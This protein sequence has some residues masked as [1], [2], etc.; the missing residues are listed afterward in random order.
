VAVDGCCPHC[1]CE[2]LHRHSE[3]VSEA[4]DLVRAYLRVRRII[5]EVRRCKNCRKRVTAP[6]PPMPFERVSC[7][8]EMMAYLAYMKLVLFVPLERL[9]RDFTAQGAPIGSA[10]LSRWFHECGQ[11]LLLVVAQMRQELL[12]GDH[13]RFD[14]TGLM[15][16]DFDM[17]GE[18]PVIHGQVIVFCT[19]ELVVFHPTESK[20]GKHIE[21]FLT[22]EVDGEERPWQ[23]TATADAVNIHDQIFNVDG[24]TES[25]CN[26]HG[27]RKFRDDAD[28]APL[29]AQEA[30]GFIGGW[31]KVEEQAKEQE[32]SGDALL[33]YRQKH[34]GPIAV[35]FRAWLDRFLEKSRLSEKN[36]VRLAV[37][38]YDNHWQPLTEFLRDPEVDLDNNLSERLLRNIALLR[39]N[40]LFSGT[41]AHV[42]RLCAML[43]ALQTCRL[44]S[45]DPYEYLVWVLPKLVVHTDNRGRDIADLTPAAFKR[46]KAA[47][48]G[49]S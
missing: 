1:Q 19:P 20:H 2:S 30:M 11:L 43:S 9:N 33:D 25:G 18:R 40:S 13:L 17:A 28:C 14:G 48:E 32:L 37:Q 44:L 7:T 46:L 24:R 21:D 29:I 26:A 6:M 49:F 39:N 27:L 3:L 12:A 16:L 23:G 36:P 15:L 38:Y 10:M 31:Y 41:G 47:P 4:Y 5:R 35:R 34:A 8:F 22:I 45:L 42:K